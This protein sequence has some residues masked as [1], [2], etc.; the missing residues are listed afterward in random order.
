MI[1]MFDGECLLCQRAVQ[2]ILKRDQNGNIHFASLQSEIGRKILSQYDQN[3][4]GN[5]SMIFIENGKLYEKSTAALRIAKKLSH[6]WP[7]CYV[8]IL[9]PKSL[10]DGM[11]DFV[12]KHRYHL[13]GKSTTCVIPKPEWKSRFM[14]EEE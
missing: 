6:L 5:Q 2:F 14:E 9:L 8:F 4:T 7:I 3:P 10:R 11:Y 12:A 13:F 1:V